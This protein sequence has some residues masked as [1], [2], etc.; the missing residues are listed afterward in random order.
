MLLERWQRYWSWLFYGLLVVSTGVAVID[1]DG[2]RRAVIVALA[3]ANST[4]RGPDERRVT[5]AGNA[6]LS[7]SRTAATTTRLANPDIVLYSLFFVISWASCCSS[8]SRRAT[9]APRA[10]AR[11]A[12]PRSFPNAPYRH[13]A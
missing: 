9:S 5:R 13:G 8:G 10:L 3:A 12:A 7:C 2:D 6:R 11:Q 1:V 4:S